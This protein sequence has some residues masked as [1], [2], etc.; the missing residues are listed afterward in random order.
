MECAACAVRIEKKLSKVKGVRSAVVNYATGEA[1]V[2]YD[3]DEKTVRLTDSARTVDLYLE[4]VTPY[5]ISWAT[6]YQ[7]LLFLS[8]TLLLLAELG[9]WFASTV[10]SLAL[11][12]GLYVVAALSV[13]YRLWSKRWFYLRQILE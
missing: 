6:Y 4:V 12:A 3:R 1:V 11:L 2:E 8:L 13:G 9:V 5:G 7:A 10:P